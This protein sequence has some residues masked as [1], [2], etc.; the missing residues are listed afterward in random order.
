MSTSP[1]RYEGRVA[2]VTGGARGMGEAEIRR[3]AAEGAKVVIADILDEEG[4]CLAK[5]IGESALFVHLDVTQEDEWAQGVAAVEDHFG[6]IDVL[7]NNAG[8]AQLDPIQT[9]SAEAFMRQIQVNALGPFLGVR[10]LVEPMKRS[11]GGAIVNV[12]S[13][14]ALSGLEYQASYSASK[15]AVRGITAVAAKE[16]GPLGIRVNTVLPGGVD[17]PMLRGP[18]GDDFDFD[19]MLSGTPVGRPGVPEE[20][21]AVVCFLC[22]PEASFVTGAE[23]AVDGGIQACLTLP[24]PRTH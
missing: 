15:H 17:T 19:A 23:V 6:R 9:I 3:F 16:L 12:A 20:V 22:A 2:I 1:G 14:A 11:G 18:L 5:E 8:I 24:P 21:A 4:R 10:T 13:V 7:V